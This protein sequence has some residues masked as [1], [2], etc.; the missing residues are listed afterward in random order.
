MVFQNILKNV[1]KEE[2]DKLLN[3]GLSSYFQSVFL[4]WKLEGNE[5]VMSQ[6]LFCLGEAGWYETLWNMLERSMLS[7][8]IIQNLLNYDHVIINSALSCLWHLTKID[9][10]ADN[11]VF[12]NEWQKIDKIFWKD[13]EDGLSNITSLI[14]LIN[15]NLVWSKKRQ[16]YLNSRSF[17]KHIQAHLP[18]IM[19]PEGEE[20]NETLLLVWANIMLKLTNSPETCEIL[21]KEMSEQIWN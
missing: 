18:R 7:K 2:M 4:K 17:A 19:N 20:R 11:I 5:D 13:W 10:I 9:T 16:D 12:K 15:S 3:N 6:F 8:Y 14:L 1:S 21:V